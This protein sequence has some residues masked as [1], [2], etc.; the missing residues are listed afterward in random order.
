MRRSHPRE[1]TK[2]TALATTRRCPQ[3]VPH[4]AFGCALRTGLIDPCLR[5]AACLLS[6]RENTRF[7]G[8]GA[9]GLKDDIRRGA[10]RAREIDET[11]EGS[12]ALAR[13]GGWGA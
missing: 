10:H 9:L 6:A 5:G 11:A 13:A 3:L 8:R 12:A 1:R 7:D 4:Q 2:P